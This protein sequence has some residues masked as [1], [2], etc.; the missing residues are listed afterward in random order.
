M[1]VRIGEMVTDS[2][3][4]QTEAEAFIHK[5]CDVDSGTIVDTLI[6]SVVIAC[7]GLLSTTVT[8]SGIV[9]EPCF[10]VY[11]VQTTIKTL[12]HILRMHPSEDNGRATELFAY[13][14]RVV[15]HDLTTL[16]TGFFALRT[17]VSEQSH[18]AV[19]RL[20]LGFAIFKSLF[21]SK[22]AVGHGLWL[23]KVMLSIETFLATLKTVSVLVF[24]Q[25]LRDLLLGSVSDALAT[26]KT[27][28]KSNYLRDLNVTLVHQVLTNL[29]EDTPRMLILS[30]CHVI[31]QLWIER[32]DDPL[33][34]EAEEGKGGKPSGEVV[35]EVTVTKM[36][37]NGFDWEVEAI[38]FLLQQVTARSMANKD[39]G[40]YVENILD[41]EI[42]VVANLCIHL[43][44]LH[45][46]RM[47][48]SYLLR[49]PLTLSDPSARDQLFI[50]MLSYPEMNDFWTQVVL[51]KVLDVH[52][53]TFV[54]M[55][56]LI[57]LLEEQ[58]QQQEDSL[59]AESSPSST[60]AT[61][62][63]EE[64]EELERD[65]QVFNKL[66]GE[67]LLSLFLSN[68]VAFPV[69]LFKSPSLRSP[70]STES[71]TE[72]SV[73]VDSTHE[74]A[75]II[76]NSAKS[77]STLSFILCWLIVLQR[78]E[79]VRYYCIHALYYCAYSY[80]AYYTYLICIYTYYTT[81]YLHMH[82]S[83]TCYISNTPYA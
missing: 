68:M 74:I 48:A 5:A 63:S 82:I 11:Q 50:S 7:Q 56:E 34:A 76:E 25:D 66:L 55:P 51:T 10:I 49:A 12:F 6:R 58:K 60:T 2:I 41:K 78:I 38:P 57:A 71:L 20:I 40:D 75:V 17:S 36:V 15:W 45:R 4:S 27:K 32:R 67:D 14:R 39:S 81:L 46:S 1:P 47:E 72:D 8:I 42:R 54:E 21:H 43:A 65:K 35:T 77:K 73:S 61:V 31:Y 69:E 28:I 83:Y 23:P 3:L 22:E 44:F 16:L 70:R 59:N 64:Q 79:S 19:D 52:C 13:L 37:S 18:N 9:S 29:S 26:M 62:F 30:L 53:V 24:P 33:K 80:Y